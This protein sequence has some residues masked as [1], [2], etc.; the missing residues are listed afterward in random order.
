[1]SIQQIELLRKVQEYG[2]TIIQWQEKI[3]ATIADGDI[4]RLHN[5]KMP[6]GFT[7][8]DCSEREGY[9]EHHT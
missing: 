5:L 6:E 4:S 1:M 3:V 7:Q 9:R 2:D 8:G